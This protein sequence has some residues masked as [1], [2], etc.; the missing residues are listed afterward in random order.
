MTTSYATYEFTQR[1]WH[2]CLVAW[3]TWM[4][5]VRHRLMT[6]SCPDV[7][8]QSRSGHLTTYWVHLSV[9]A[10]ASQS[11]RVSCHTAQCFHSYH[12]RL[13]LN[14]IV[15]HGQ[16]TIKHIYLTAPSAASPKTH[17]TNKTVKTRWLKTPSPMSL[18]K[19]VSRC[20]TEDQPRNIR[21]N[22]S[23]YS[24]NCMDAFC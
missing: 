18:N 8:V 9:D 16:L 2:A 14:T 23:M 10:T 17:R 3:W 4:E 24:C 7:W 11:S 19:T 15:C 22:S 13:Y 12:S 5:A 20:P 21:Q 1:T 6:P